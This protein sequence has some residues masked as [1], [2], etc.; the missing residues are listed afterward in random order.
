MAVSPAP[1]SLAVRELAKLRHRGIVSIA[2]VSDYRAWG[3][4]RR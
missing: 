2:L 1:A 4:G 3:W